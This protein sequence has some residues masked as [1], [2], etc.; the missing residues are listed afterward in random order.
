[1]RVIVK[2]QKL[3]ILSKTGQQIANMVVTRFQELHKLTNYKFKKLLSKFTQ[4][5]KVKQDA[6]KTDQ[7]TVGLQAPLDM[8]PESSSL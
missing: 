2:M 4:I 1:M 3:I 7:K 6:T 5:K 8:V